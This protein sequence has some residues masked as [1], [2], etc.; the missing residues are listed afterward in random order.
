MVQLLIRIF[1]RLVGNVK[2]H[3]LEHRLFSTISLLNGVANIGGSFAYL[4]QGGSG[5]LQFAINAGTGVLFLGL[6]YLSRFR[7]IYYILYWPFNLLIL[8]FLATLW[9]PNGGSH[10]GSSYYLIPAL[11]IAT[12]LA[13]SG[14]TIVLVFLLYAAVAVALLFIE[15]QRPDLIAMPAVE[16]R[17][18]D[19]VLNYPFVQIFSSGLVVVLSRNVH[20]EREKSDKLLLNILPQEIAEELK[21]TDQVAPQSY[22]QVTVLFTD[23]VGFTRIAENLPPQDLLRELDSCFS[24]FD[25]II[26]K[27]KIEKIKTIGDSYMCAGGVPHRNKTNAIDCVLAALNMITYMKRLKADREAHGLPC[28]EIRLGIHT[29]HLV[30]GV[31]GKEKFAYDIWGDTV[32]LASRMES[33]GVPMQV[34]ISRATYELVSNLFDCE[35]RGAVQAKNKGEIDMYLVRGVKAEFKGED[36]KL[37]RKFVEAYKEVGAA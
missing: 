16:D 35:F 24:S 17:F 13:R 4:L 37:N 34:N 26:K 2:E 6:Y 19:I 29:G 10:G 31:I 1:Y 7:G 27:H 32:N 20:A 12:I 14:R 36:G 33:S 21:K 22:D 11:M 25:R 5:L 9:F 28:W 8:G 3:S 30:A 23:L 15:H 18:L